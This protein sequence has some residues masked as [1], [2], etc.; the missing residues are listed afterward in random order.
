MLFSLTFC[1]SYPH[2]DNF[3]LL[4]LT[5]S[6]QSVAYGSKLLHRFTYWWVRQVSSRPKKLGRDKGLRALPSKTIEYKIYFFSC[7]CF[8]VAEK[9]LLFTSPSLIQGALNF[10]WRAFPS[11]M[12]HFSNFWRVSYF[13]SANKGFFSSSWH[14]MSIKPQ[15]KKNLN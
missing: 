15:K 13:S 14:A 7:I 3:Y 10:H 2:C 4:G 8:I 9:Y 6:E 5:S 12:D 11:M 1:I